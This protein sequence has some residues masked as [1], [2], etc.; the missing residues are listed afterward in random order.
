MTILCTKCVYKHRYLFG[1]Y[2]WLNANV[3]FINYGMSLADARNVFLP[4]ESLEKKNK[5]CI[6]VFL[7]CEQ[8][9]RIAHE[10]RCKNTCYSE[11]TNF[12]E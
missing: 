4:V 2:L 11:F 3:R 7:Y 12:L 1:L 6:I 10:Q 8:T 9:R 5:K